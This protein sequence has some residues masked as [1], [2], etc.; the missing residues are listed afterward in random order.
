MG[1]P[2]TVLIVILL[3]TLG[4]P[5]IIGAQGWW[6]DRARR[7]VVER[8]RQQ[9]QA[10]LLVT[11]RRWPQADPSVAPVL[12]SASTV[13]SLDSTRFGLGA[14]RQIVGGEMK[15][16]T[17]NLALARDEATERVRAQATQAGCDC[18]LNLRF[19]TSQV[20]RT[21]CEIIAYGTAIRRASP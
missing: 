8:F 4:P 15:M 11:T 9:N 17:R 21:A 19:E 3:L 5:L 7:A 1:G 12:V 14:L 2:A 6:R 18:V 16:F 20:S 13:R 10:V